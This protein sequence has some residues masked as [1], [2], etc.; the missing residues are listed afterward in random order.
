MGQAEDDA[1]VGLGG[2]LQAIGHGVAL[3]GQGMVARRLERVGQAAKHPFAVVAHRAE[4]AVHDIGRAHHLGPE[5]LGDGLMAQA[6]AEQGNR[7]GEALDQ[8]ETD[9]GAVGIAGAGRHDNR[10]G[11]AIEQLIDRNRI[12]TLHRNLGAKL[13][14]VMR[15]IIGKAVIIID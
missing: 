6:D 8:F 3:D 13:P 2:D 14:Q 15:Q 9:A 12:I 7:T 11:R 1:V 10:L 4:L 5:G